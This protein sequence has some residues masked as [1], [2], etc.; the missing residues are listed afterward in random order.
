MTD[1]LRRLLALLTLLAGVTASAQA[2]TAVKLYLTAMGNGPGKQI[3]CGDRLVSL[4]RT[5]PFTRTPLRAALTALLESRPSSP[6][7]YNVFERSSLRVERID[8]RG[9][10]AVVRLSGQL[11]LGGVCDYPRV[12]G[13]LQATARQFPSVRAACFFVD[14]VP[15]EQLLDESGRRLPVDVCT[16]R[17]RR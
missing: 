11:V 6:K 5:L 8:L 1:R 13:Q 9:G 16:S 14:G 12:T 4:S 10:N 2:T 15:L 7:V 3:G 17:V